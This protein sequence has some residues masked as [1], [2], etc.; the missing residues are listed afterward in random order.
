MTSERLNELTRNLIPNFYN[1]HCE[2]LTTTLRS[3][4]TA[5]QRVISEAKALSTLTGGVKV[6]VL[7]KNI[8]FKNGDLKQHYYLVYFIDCP[9]L[10]YT[11][12]IIGYACNGKWSS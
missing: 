9:A 12:K 10:D 11:G 2:S 7:E 4:K 6:F 1:G 8:E 5:K 3:G